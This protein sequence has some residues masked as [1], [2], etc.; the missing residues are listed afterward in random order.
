MF[1]TILLVPFIHDMEILL[2]MHKLG[3]LMQKH[4]SFGACQKVPNNCSVKEPSVLV[5]Y[6]Q[7]FTT[8]REFC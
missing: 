1:V 6:S 5:P 4:H 3:N 8:G 7:E 2:Y